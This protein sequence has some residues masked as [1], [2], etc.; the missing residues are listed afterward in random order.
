MWKK[1]EGR[2]EH[3]SPDPL[4]GSRLIT[5]AVNRCISQ[6]RFNKTH[7]DGYY[8]CFGESQN[9]AKFLW[10]PGPLLRS[11]LVASSINRCISSRGV[12]QAPYRQVLLVFWR[13]SKF[14][15]IQNFEFWVHTCHSLLR[16]YVTSPSCPTALRNILCRAQRRTK[17]ARTKIR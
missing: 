5:S 16:H 11:N 4:L 13:K 15:K 2:G 8:K 12:Q 14:R 17:T 10:R 3:L 6:E 1:R 9:F 7:I